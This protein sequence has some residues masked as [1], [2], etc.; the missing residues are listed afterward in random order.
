[1]NPV[2]EQSAELE[3]SQPCGALTAMLVIGG[4]MM[5]SILIAAVVLFN[6]LRRYVS[7]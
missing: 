4:L 6:A 5:S 2:I 1:M 3:H 7:R